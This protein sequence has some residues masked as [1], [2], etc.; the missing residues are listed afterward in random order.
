MKRSDPS[1]KEDVG[2]INSKDMKIAKMEVDAVTDLVNLGYSDSPMDGSPC[3]G[4]MGLS[5]NL[6]VSKHENKIS[7]RGQINRPDMSL[8]PH[9]QKQ[10]S[11]SEKFTIKRK[12]DLF[13]NEALNNKGKGEGTN[14][15]SPTQ[16]Q[17]ELELDLI[18]GRNPPPPP[19]GNF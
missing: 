18:M 8:N 13:N 14:C 10:P 17:Y 12:L 3:G 16:P 2:K 7:L 5:K 1:K 4:L 15:H 11:C 6:E 19:P 9:K